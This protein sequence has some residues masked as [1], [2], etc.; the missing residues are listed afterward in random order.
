MKTKKELQDKLQKLEERLEL[1]GDD[2]TRTD[3]YKARVDILKWAL[4]LDDELY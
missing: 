3:V 4:G 1:L 2:H